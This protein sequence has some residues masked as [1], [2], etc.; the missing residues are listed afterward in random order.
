M[1][2]LGHKRIH[3]SQPMQKSGSIQYMPP[4]LR[5]APTGQ[6]S[7]QVPQPM[8]APVAMVQMCFSLAMTNTCTWLITMLTQGIHHTFYM[9]K[10]V[11]FNGHF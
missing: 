6:T 11:G 7:I 10:A 3:L 5:T 1:H 2:I 9:F 4:D 8:Q